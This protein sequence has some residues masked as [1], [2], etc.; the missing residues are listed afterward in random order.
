M[1]CQP[2][3]RYCV[4][5]LSPLLAQ[6]LDF[7]VGAS[8]YS[9]TARTVIAKFILGQMLAVNMFA[10]CAMYF[11]FWLV[12][13]FAQATLQKLCPR[14]R[15]DAVASGFSGCYHAHVGMA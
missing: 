10:V 15:A 8:E 14:L 7:S 1:N 6:Q 11:G 2:Q 12:K 4:L 5:S 3:S 13:Q 9:G